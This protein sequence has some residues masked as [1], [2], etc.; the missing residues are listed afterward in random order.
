MLVD[1]KFGALTLDGKH[2]TILSQK[3]HP[4]AGQLVV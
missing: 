2:P 3:R 1:L 4:P